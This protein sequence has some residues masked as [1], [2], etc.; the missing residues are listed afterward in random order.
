MFG[1][2]HILIAST[3]F[4]VGSAFAST[5]SMAAEYPEKPVSLVVNFSAGGSTDTAARLMVSEATETLGQGFVVKNKSGAGGTLG[6]AE[7]ARSDA[8]GYTIG[9][10]NMPAL[11]IIPQLREVPY[12]PFGD[13]VHI[14]AV[15]PYEYAIFVRG[16]AP[17]QTWEEFE[18]H[19]KENPG[20]VTY[21]SVGT[22]TTNHL[23]MERM[24]EERDLEWKHVPFQ[25]GVKATAALMGG[26]V[27]AINNTMASVASALESGEL[28][29]LLVTS[30]ERFD[31]VPEVPTMKEAGFGFSQVSYMSIVGPKGMPEKAQEKLEAAFKTAA[32]SD[33]AQSAM[34]KLDLHPRFVSGEEYAEMLRQM[35]KEWSATLD[36]LEQ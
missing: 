2:K 33:A 9:T 29:A 14:A 11:A 30:E 1:K 34:G 27:D 5:G 26:H 17:W 16:D 21:G 6:V 36:G 20:D 18:A 8:D 31:L 28:R 3:A 7:V 4:A 12:E 24:A 32:E 15:M 22:G 35:T 13:L 23:T 10:A 25:G 19:I